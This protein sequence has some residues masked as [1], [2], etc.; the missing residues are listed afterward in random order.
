[1]KSRGVSLVAGVAVALALS[2][3]TGTAQD[4]GAYGLAAVVQSPTPSTEG[5]FGNSIDLDRGRLI[6]GEAFGDAGGT[7]RAGRAHLFTAAGELLRSFQSPSPRKEGNF[8][9]EEYS[10]KLVA[11]NGG[12]CCVGETRAQGGGKAHL[13][14]PDGALAISLTPAEPV[15]GNTREYGNTLAM[16]EGLLLVGA[17]NVG[18]FL[19]D[20]SGTTQASLKGADGSVQDGYGMAVAMRGDTVVVTQDHA[21]VGGVRDAG[22]AYLYDARG[23]LKRAVRAPDPPQAALFGVSA[24]TDGELVVIGAPEATV[25]G[26]SRAGLVYLFG[27]D[28]ELRH[29]LSS[30]IP[31]LYFGVSVTVDS[32]RLIVG[33]SGTKVDGQNGAGFAFVFDQDGKCIATLRPPKSSAGA[34]FGWSVAASDGVIAVSAPGEEAGGKAAAGKVYLFAPQ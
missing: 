1:M 29:V 30:P 5:W 2:A 28:G 24:D 18:A 12:W 20:T 26:R 22:M 19:Y 15:R 10:N 32:G 27:A 17:Y 34:S 33:A 6:V 4:T 31:S 9:G 11:V 3:P 25:D 16:T 23:T 21:A 14:G 8:G 13:F 7:R